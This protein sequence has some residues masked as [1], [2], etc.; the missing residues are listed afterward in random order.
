[1]LRESGWHAGRGV[2]IYISRKSILSLYKLQFTKNNFGERKL[3]I[4]RQISYRKLIPA[5]V[6]MVVFLKIWTLLLFLM[7]LSIA[8]MLLM[9]IV[10]DDMNRLIE[11]RQQKYQ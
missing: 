8:T 6:T 1:M 5:D 7:M 9:R 3:E 10:A 11:D 4:W 2:K